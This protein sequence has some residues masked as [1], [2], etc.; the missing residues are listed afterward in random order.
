MCVFRA[1]CRM[2]MCICVCVLSLL[3][4]SFAGAFFFCWVLVAAKVSLL[5]PRERRV[6]ALRVFV[7]SLCPKKF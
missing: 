7:A 2:Y 3:L 1:I 6:N 5:S 4:L